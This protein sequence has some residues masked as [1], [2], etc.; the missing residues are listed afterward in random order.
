MAGLGVVLA[1]AGCATSVPERASPIEGVALAKLVAAPAGGLPTKADM[2]LTLT[3]QRS[4]DVSAP[5]SLSSGAP[6]MVQPTPLLTS[7][8]ADALIAR[9]IAEHEMRRP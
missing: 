9:A 4:G 8:D 2:P 6:A 3:S 1:S 7:L 5:S